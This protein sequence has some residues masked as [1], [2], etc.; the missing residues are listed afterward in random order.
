M[1]N[2]ATA[3]HYAQKLEGK[4]NYQFFS[5]EMNLSSRRQMSLEASIRQALDDDLFVLHYQPIIDVAS[6]RTKALEALLRSEHPS[7]G[8]VPIGSLI[9]VAEQTGLIAPIGEWVLKSV[10]AQIKLWQRAGLNVPRISI[11]LSAVQL[12][13]EEAMSRVVTIV[14]RMNLPP[15][16]IQFEVTETAILRD[17]EAAAQAL[18]HIRELGIL[19]ALDDFGTGQSS[20]GY[21]RRFQPD[22]L[23][24][25]RCFIGEITTSHSDETLVSAIISMAQRLDME[26]VAEGVETEKQLHKLCEIGCD[27]IQ[28]FYFARPMHPD[29]LQSWLFDQRGVN[30]VR[31]KPGIKGRVGRVA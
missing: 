19:I 9:A 20:L 7:F 26:V 6:G 22:I 1:R 5:E 17:S 14:S 3:R 30:L 11:N 10:I 23:K 16:A 21:L 2:S 27:A 8:G 15:T 4:N 31:D 25:D 24:I 18:E 12:S 28:G 29:R 13:S